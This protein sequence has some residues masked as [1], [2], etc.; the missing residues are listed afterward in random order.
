MSNWYWSFIDRREDDDEDQE[1][2]QDD[3]EDDEPDTSYWVGGT[4]PWIDKHDALP[5]M[6]QR[7]FV[8]VANGSVYETM[9]IGDKADDWTFGASDILYWMPEPDVSGLDGVTDA[10]WHGDAP[11]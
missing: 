11:R 4:T 3:W 10:R 5:R 9:Y 8:V 1:G 7:V 6:W 2:T